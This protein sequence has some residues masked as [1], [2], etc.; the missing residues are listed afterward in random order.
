MSKENVALFIKAVNKNNELSLKISRT[1][2]TT[3]W[4]ALAEEAGFEFT[5]SEFA[6]VVSSMLGRKL[7]PANAV[8]AYMATSNVMSRGELSQSALESVVEK[9][10]AYQA[11]TEAGCS[12]GGHTMACCGGDAKSGHGP[13]GHAGHD[14][15]CPMM[16]GANAAPEAPKPSN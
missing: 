5:A 10:V 4:V 9:L 12:M 2:T 6:D 1:S 11:S 7:T 16:K 13:M 14:E 3:E 15:H 8:D